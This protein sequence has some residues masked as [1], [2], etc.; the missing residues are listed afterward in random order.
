MDLSLIQKEI[1]L[2]LIEDYN[3][4][5]DEKKQESLIKE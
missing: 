4:T 2:R 3:R 1:V 5:S